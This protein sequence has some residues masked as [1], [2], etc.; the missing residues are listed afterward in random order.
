MSALQGRESTDLAGKRNQSYEQISE[1]FDYFQRGI[2]IVSKTSDAFH[3]QH[4][5]WSNSKS[6]SKI[7]YC[8]WLVPPV[9][10]AAEISKIISRLASYHDSPMFGPHVTLASSSAAGEREDWANE[11]FRLV[12]DRV[13]PQREE[14]LDVHFDYP[15]IGDT[16]HQ[17]VLVE[18]RKGAGF[19]I[20]QR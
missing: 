7:L 17:C 16:R 4:A 2:R 5:S 6:M 18:A 19:E 10:K 15:R 14:L 9:E 3:R 11:W 12:L 20:L 13:K 8:L 1:T